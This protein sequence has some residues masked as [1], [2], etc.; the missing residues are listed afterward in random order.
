M[1]DRFAEMVKKQD[2]AAPAL[3]INN[4]VA[5][6]SEEQIGRMVGLTKSRLRYWARTDFFKPS[7]V[8]EDGRLPYSRFY[9]FKD[10]VA[11]RTLEMLRV[12]NGVP[13]Q[14]LRKVADN[15][16]HMKDELWSST[17]LFVQDKKVLVVN[18]EFGQPQEI[19]SGQYVLRIPL[20]EIIEETRNDILAF[21]SRPANTVGHLSRNRGIARNALVVSGTRIPV[22]SVLRLHEDGYTVD[23]IIAEYPDLTA[24]DIE[25]ALTHGRHIAA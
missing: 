1:L 3:D 23:Q 2:R 25:A 15:L 20:S 4:V 10:V 9:S 16:A 24:E 12:R 21:R 22:G 8:E 11:L 18:P 19:V 5:A 13:L 6:Y 14:H 17:S 7:F